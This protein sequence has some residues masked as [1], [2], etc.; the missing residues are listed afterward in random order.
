MNFL[1]SSYR[2]KTKAAPIP[3]STFDH[4]PL[5]NALGPSSRAIFRQQSRVPVYM[6]SAAGDRQR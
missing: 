2:T 6:M 5:K 1:I 4:A 3:R